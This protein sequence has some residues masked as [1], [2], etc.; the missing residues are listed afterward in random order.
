MNSKLVKTLCISFIMFFS[1]FFINIDNA[2][3]DGDGTGYAK[4]VYEF[5]EDRYNISP[6]RYY[7]VT[8]V[9][10]KVGNSFDSYKG[11]ATVDCT[12]GDEK[13]SKLYSD[14]CSFSGTEYNYIF[15]NMLS[16]QQ[17]FKKNVLTDKNNHNN[18]T[19]GCPS[20]I[21]INKDKYNNSMSLWFDEKTCNNKNY[22]MKCS[23]IADLKDNKSKQEG[24]PFDDGEKK[25]DQWLDDSTGQLTTED[26]DTQDIKSIIKW[27]TDS[28]G[29]GASYQY[30]NCD[31]IPENIRNFLSSFFT[32]ISIIGMIL[33]VV[34]SAIEFIKA[35]TGSDEDG[36]KGA[37]KH[38][39]IRIICAIILLLLPMLITWI[40]N[41]ANNN[42]YKIDD[43]GNYVIGDNGNP[44][45]NK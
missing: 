6:Y 26:P 31:I 39:F 38:T 27:G 2:E 34:M 28:K 40:L 22:G 29:T 7:V 16:Y 43:K 4:C 11:Y 17:H 8:V 32:I 23:V 21:Y 35:V 19:W 14:L 13:D 41:I 10:Y 45:C 24:T 33:L 30:G 20:K 5:T 42:N 18:P 12:K 9:A 25:E 3:A 15:H 37:I 44:L 36:L 1:V